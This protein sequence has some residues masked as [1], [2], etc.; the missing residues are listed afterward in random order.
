[1]E[2]VVVENKEKQ[3]GLC[4]VSTPW[5]RNLRLGELT[6]VVGREGGR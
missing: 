2:Q 4:D 6:K 5:G 3:K 1:M